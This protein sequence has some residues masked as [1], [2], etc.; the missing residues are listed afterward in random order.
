[1]GADNLGGELLPRGANRVAFP[2]TS[3]FNHQFPIL[4]QCLAEG[5]GRTQGH[6]AA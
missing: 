4:L 5:I 6:G 3:T 1:M 2:P